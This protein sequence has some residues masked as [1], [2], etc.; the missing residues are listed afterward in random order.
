MSD[1]F[2]LIR[3]NPRKAL[4]KLSFPTIL[5][6]FLMFLNQLIDSFW[7]SGI[8][9]E[10]LAAFGFIFPLYLVIIGLGKGLG[11]GANSLISRYVGG[12]DLKMQITQLFMQLF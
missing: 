1:N 6:M 4:N 2:E 12:G 7:V 5:S 11:A 3:S 8:N 9:G 10:A